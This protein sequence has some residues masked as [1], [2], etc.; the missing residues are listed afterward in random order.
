MLEMGRVSRIQ[1]KCKPIAHPPGLSRSAVS[2]KTQRFPEARAE[3]A[4]QKKHR[5]FLHTETW[6][7]I[8]TILVRKGAPRD[9]Q[10]PWITEDT[11]TA[12]LSS[13]KEVG[14]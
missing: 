9:K 13:K 8:W 7:L 11:P 12:L 5:L 6:P 14:R 10:P 1:Y 2:S 3:R 4:V